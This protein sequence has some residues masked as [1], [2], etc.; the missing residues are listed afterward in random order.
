[1]IKQVFFGPNVPT[2]QGRVR[3]V[4]CWNVNQGLNAPELVPRKRYLETQKNHFRSMEGSV[5][6]PSI[7]TRVWMNKNKWFKMHSE[8][9]LVYWN[10]GGMFA[11]VV[12]TKENW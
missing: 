5:L 1:M 2:E 7:T 6:V 4:R 10:G 3:E 11:P 9:Q 8:E 12:C